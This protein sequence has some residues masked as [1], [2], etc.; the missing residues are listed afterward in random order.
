M[1]DVPVD[2]LVVATVMPV[3]TDVVEK[4]DDPVD[5][6]FAK[7]TPA[8]AFP[9]DPFVY[10][11]EWAWVGS[12]TTDVAVCVCDTTIASAEPPVASTEYVEPAPT[13]NRSLRS[14]VPL[15]PLHNTHPEGIEPIE[16]D[17]NIIPP[18]GIGVGGDGAVPM[19][20]Y[21]LS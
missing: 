3:P 5:A 18:E 14:G 21:R 11:A 7:G 6:K 20:P 19:I 2:A 8:P 12:V 1:P 16:P 4:L 17:H 15:D 13:I 10:P 9:D